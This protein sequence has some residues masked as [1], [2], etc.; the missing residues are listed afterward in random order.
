MAFSLVLNDGTN[1]IAPIPL[2]N[3]AQCDQKSP[4]ASQVAAYCWWYGSMFDVDITSILRHILILERAT[5]VL[6]EVREKENHVIESRSRQKLE[7]FIKPNALDCQSNIVQHIP[8]RSRL[9]DGL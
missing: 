6:P 1:H 3:V 9:F 4:P 7:K 5:K 8:Y 2:I